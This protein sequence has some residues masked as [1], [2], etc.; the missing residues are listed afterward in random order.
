MKPHQIS[1]RTA[2]ENDVPRCAELL[3]IL[4]SL[5][6]EFTPDVELQ[7]RGVSMI[8]HNPEL[9]RIF[10]AEVDG[11]I[12]G[13]V[14]LLFTVSTFLGSKVALLEDMIVDPAWQGKGL[15][16]HLINHALD[17]AR[18]EGLARITLLTDRD[19][20]TA[21]HFY[22]SKSFIRSEMVVF[23]NMLSL[24]SNQESDLLQS[25]RPFVRDKD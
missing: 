5:E 1:V 19:N 13:M 12:Q 4:F 3:G 7:S 20:E 18:R 22:A 15:G 14:M 6:H 8:I 21:Q 24:S 9:G 11:V 23:R 10:V 2:V 17:F 25:G 16:S